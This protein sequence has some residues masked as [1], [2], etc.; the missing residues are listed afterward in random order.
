MGLGTEILV[1]AGLLVLS[2]FFSSSEVALISL[3]KFKVRHMLQ[4]KRFGS[5]FIKRLKDEPQRMLATILIGN[6]VVNVGASALLTSIMIS[7]FENYAV[8][9]TTGVMTFLILVFG[10]ITPKSIAVQ[11]N[12]RISQLVALPVWYLSLFLAPVLI[13]LDKCLNKFIN[14]FGIKSREKT[15]TEEEIISVIKIAEEEGSIEKIERNLIG[16]VFR[17]SDMNVGEITTPV[18]DM[19]V[20]SAKSSVNDALRIV[21]R[22]KFSRIPVYAKHRDNIT[23][24]VYF[25]D[26]MAPVE[27][28]KKRI[29]V[30]KIMK[31]PYFVP[32]SKKISNLLRHFQKRKEHMAIV[33]NEHGALEGLVTLEDILEEIVGDI[34]DETDKIDPNI[35]SISEKAWLIKGKTEIDEINEKLKMK[36]KGDDYDTF[37]GFI[38]K[39]AGKIPDE[40]EEIKYNNFKIKIVKIDHHRISLVRVE[41]VLVR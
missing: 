3:S 20:I 27:R 18:R 17:F 35:R 12:E 29:N 32:T 36:L 23:G 10:E 2:G 30:D 16:K 6:N 28:N 37:S 33:V 15:I 1:L 39:R 24:V 26:L 34:M 9:I 25:K 14:L 22:S 7:R 11:H 13:V 19:T 21:M 41:K 38:L 8:G 31:E 40:K 4:Q 5:F